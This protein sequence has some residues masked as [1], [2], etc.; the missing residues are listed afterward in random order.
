MCS[1]ASIFLTWNDYFSILH[2]KTTTH[3]FA[4]SPLALALTSHPLF[5]YFIS[6]YSARTS[7]V[8]LATLARSS[9]LVSASRHE[10]FSHAY[11]SWL[12]CILYMYS[13]YLASTTVHASLLYL[14][15]SHLVLRVSMHLLHIIHYTT[16]L[17]L[18]S[19][20]LGRA[21]SA[22]V[23][24]RLPNI[25]C[26]SCLLCTCSTTLSYRIREWISD[27]LRSHRGHRKQHL[28][29]VLCKVWGGERRDSKMLSLLEGVKN[30]VVLKFCS[31]IYLSITHCIM[32]VRFIDIFIEGKCG[33]KAGVK[34]WKIRMKIFQTILIICYKVILEE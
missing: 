27:E 4:P 33:K 15:T 17:Y 8:L 3:H 11:A 16:A 19:V 5:S 29:S 22:V 20:L 30:L 24:Q 9:L 13:P 21:S 18:Y 10:C 32:K 12:T 14:Y 2:T 25:R 23:L 7:Y 26:L 28:C 31:V 34:A 6:F 1:S